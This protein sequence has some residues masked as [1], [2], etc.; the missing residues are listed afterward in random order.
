MNQAIQKIVIVGGGTAGWMAAAMLSQYFKNKSV[1]IELIE[2]D[3]IGTVGVGE[4]TVP[5]IARLNQMLQIKE[6]DFI[7]ATQATFKLGIEFKDWYKKDD[8]FFHPFADYGTSIGGKSFYAC[9]LKAH[10]AG[11]QGRLEEFCFSTQLARQNRFAQPDIQT[12]TP[13]IF[14]NYAYHFDAS[15]YAKFLRTYAEA[16]GVKRIEGKIKAVNVNS[17]NGFVASVD[18][19]SGINVSG[20]LFIDCSGFKALLIEETLKTGYEDWS[21]WLPCDSAIALQTQ[22]IEEPAPY[23]RST[24]HEAGWQWRIPLQNRV[25]NGYVYCS[26][27]ISDEQ[28][29]KTLVGNVTGKHLTQPRVI[30]FTTGMRK[31]FFNKNCVALGLASGFLE[32]LESTSISLIQTGVEKLLEFFPDRSFDQHKIDQVNE[33]NRQEYEGVRDFIILHYKANQRTDS[34]FW[35]SVRDMDIPLTLQTKIA[36]FKCDGQFIRYEQDSF[37]D[38]SWLSM[39]NGFH[40]F[41]EQC[42]VDVADMDVHQLKLTLDKMKAV[43]R[44][45]LQYAPSHKDFLLQI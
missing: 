45:G 29:I 24:A 6:L 30:K 34:E 41:P 42:S 9:W 15:L 40:I 32:P 31:K 4:A 36:A 10:K 37:L 23:T 18:L 19:E 3:E 35:K 20:E 5:G 39:Y 1:S 33:I 26:R 25:G 2:S 22:N 16:R 11:Y 43:L 38:A 7:R 21:H 14:Y 44:D 8:S 17:E 27:Y 13:L 12:T 28:A